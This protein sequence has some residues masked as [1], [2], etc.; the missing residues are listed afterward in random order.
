MRKKLA[1]SFVVLALMCALVG[2]ATF[3]LFNDSQTISGNTFST[4]ILDVG[5][6]ISQPI[7]E[8]NIAPGW[9]QTITG[10]FSNTGNY[11]AYFRVSLAN[12]VD[13]GLA[14]YLTY[15][16]TYDGITSPITGNLSDLSSNPIVSGE[17]NKGA[18]VNYT[19]IIA[20]PDTVDNEAQGKT[21]SA[22]VYIDSVQKDNNSSMIGWP[23]H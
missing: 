17:L 19:L 22:T 9:S 12:I 6:T 15:S 5:A 20:L 13:T 1:M 14:H 3:A 8:T 18:T 11:D 7:G 21:C 2:G 16:L 23:T 4:G 10:A